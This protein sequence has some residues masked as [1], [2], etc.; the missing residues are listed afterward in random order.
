[1]IGF[2][3]SLLNKETLSNDY[4][5]VPQYVTDNFWYSQSIKKY[6]NFTN[7]AM[8][9]VEAIDEIRRSYKA[10]WPESIDIQ[11]YMKEDI[12]PTFMIT[13]LTFY[14]LKDLSFYRINK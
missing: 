2:D 12:D 4:F 1:M 9:K 11:D 5:I 13:E 6:Y 8:P 3:R 14:L 7:T 10:Y